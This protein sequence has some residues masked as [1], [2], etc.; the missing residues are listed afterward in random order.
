MHTRTSTP[1][2]TLYDQVQEDLIRVSFEIDEPLIEEAQRLGCH[3]SQE[4]A[5]TAALQEYVQRRKQIKILSLFGKIEYDPT[6]NHKG[7]ANPKMWVIRLIQFL[8]TRFFH[9]RQSHGGLVLLVLP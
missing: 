9:A 2:D 1:L 3:C 8:C 5:V 7:A 4:A 6:Y